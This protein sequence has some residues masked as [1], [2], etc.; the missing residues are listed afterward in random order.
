MNIECIERKH[1]LTSDRHADNFSFVVENGDVDIR[2][3]VSS[4][5]RRCKICV[6]EMSILK[7]RT[8]VQ[9]RKRDA[10]VECVRVN[11]QLVAVKAVRAVPESLS[12][13]YYSLS[14]GHDIIWELFDKLIGLKIW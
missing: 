2:G 10:H 5:E 8:R 13:V 1:Q 4:F 12:I 6:P 7:S 3:E 9:A 14:D 11:V